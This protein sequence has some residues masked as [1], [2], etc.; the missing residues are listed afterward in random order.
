MTSEASTATRSGLGLEVRSAQT[1]K[2]L[3]RLLYSMLL[4]I[5]DP[6]EPT[7]SE[8]VR[9]GGP[10]RPNFKALYSVTL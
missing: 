5:G 7:H 9:P 1:S 4:F 3:I 6:S 8:W 2:H 10:I